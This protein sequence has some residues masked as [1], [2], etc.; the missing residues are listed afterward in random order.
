MKTR[1]IAL[2]DQWRGGFW[3]VPSLCL[4]T[5]VVLGLL[6]PKVD[7]AFRVHEVPGL[8]WIETT[9]PSARSVLTALAGALVTV[10]GVVLS[11]TMVTLSLTTSQYGPRLLRSFVQNNLTQLTIGLFLGASLYSLLVLRTVE[12]AGNST[13]VPHLSVAAAV[14]VTALG[15]GQLVYFIHGVASAIQAQNV[16]WS[17]ARELD[18]AIES[19]YPSDVG[20]SGEG[21]PGS[22][23][24][25]TQEI[26]AG[27]SL[28]QVLVT[29]V[30]GYLQA[31]DIDG[32]T[33]LARRHDVRFHLEIQPGHFL[34]RGTEVARVYDV[35]R[36][37]PLS[38]EELADLQ[39]RLSDHLITGRYRT[40]RQDIECAVLELVEVALRALSPGINDPRTAIACIDRLGA[41]LHRLASRRPPSAEVRDDEG[42]IRLVRKTIDFD[43]V[44]DEAYQQIRQYG[45]SSVAVT[46]RLIDTLLAIAPEAA[47]CRRVRAI[48]RQADMLGRSA[49]RNLPE[50]ND[51]EDV[52]KRLAQLEQV[53]K[54][55]TSAEADEE[56]A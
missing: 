17:V 51:L 11:A 46:I 32:V 25:S 43:E 42:T 53:L 13:F 15:V 49:E 26:S 16:V 36:G 56:T 7:E 28:G 9:G 22:E 23:S 31:I 41:A 14:T 2:W 48:R 45:A 19:L 50:E 5:A 10:G 30:E 12:R 37:D 47:R 6:L 27:E 8:G 21:S 24:A 33:E 39:R 20:E 54:D 40:P 38:D 3:F 1:L 29:R 52:R 55:C 18:A 35:S 4:S 34:I 44:L